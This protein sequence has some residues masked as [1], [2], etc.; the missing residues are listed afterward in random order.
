MRPPPDAEE[1]FVRNIGSYTE[2]DAP[3]LSFSFDHTDLRALREAAATEGADHLSHLNRQLDRL[4]RA[5]RQ[6][7]NDFQQPLDEAWELCYRMAELKERE[8]KQGAQ[9]D[10]AM[11]ELEKLKRELQQSGDCNEGVSVGKAALATTQAE[12][13][14]LVVEERRL[15]TEQ[16]RVQSDLAASRQSSLQ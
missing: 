16:S 9:R 8:E 10:A 1:A 2:G 5:K 12:T 3:L 15:Q 14:R 11:E 7:D 4:C 6:L 13:D